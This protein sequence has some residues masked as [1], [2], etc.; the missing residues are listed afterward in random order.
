MKFRVLSRRPT[1]V[2]SQASTVDDHRL[3]LPDLILSQCSDETLSLNCTFSPIAFTVTLL[4]SLPLY[5]YLFAIQ[6][7][8]SARAAST[9]PQQGSGSLSTPIIR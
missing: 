4:K 5:L 2:Q 9:Q 7:F 3:L 8:F 1:T 6:S